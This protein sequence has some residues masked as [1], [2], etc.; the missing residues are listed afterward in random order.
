[1]RLEN[2]VCLVTGGG[3][4]IGKATSRLMAEEGAAVAVVGRTLEEIDETCR[5]IQ[6]N[7]GRSKSLC[8]DISR[9]DEIQGAI[10]EAAEWGGGLDCVFANAGIN[11][12]WAPIDQLAVEEWEQTISVNLTGT[13]LTLKYA[14]P[15][16][17]ARGGS[18]VINASINGTRVFSNS[19]ATAYASTKAAQVAMTKMLAL[20]LASD[21]IR[22]NA[23]CP[24]AIDTEISDNTEK[25]GGDLGVDVHFPDG[26]H[27]LRG[28]PGSSADV[29]RT[30][31]FLLSDDARHITGTEIWIDGGESLIGINE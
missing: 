16:L 18:V 27:P 13:F 24:G 12:V 17:R 10:E 11:G 19:G 26:W 15:H 2:K 23:V 25:R 20:E 8:A 31:V 22:V 30:V 5:E 4:G 9:P 3:S 29:A 7:G 14:V 1:M 6:R 28:E 21:A